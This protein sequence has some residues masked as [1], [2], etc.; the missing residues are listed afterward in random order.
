MQT[1]AKNQTLNENKVSDFIR[2]YLALKEKEIPNKGEVYERFKRRFPVPNSDD[3]KSA[4]E[5]LRTL[6]RRSTG[7]Y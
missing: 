7:S 2:D 5:E 3:L 1:N 4:L 6:S